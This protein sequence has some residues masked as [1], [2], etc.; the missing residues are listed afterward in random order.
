MI[1]LGCREMCK[2]VLEVPGTALRCSF[3]TASSERRARHSSER[4]PGSV[5]GRPASGMELETRESDFFP[6]PAFQ[7]VPSSTIVQW[8]QKACHR[9]GS[10][11]LF[12]TLLQ[13]RQAGQPTPSA[14]SLVKGRCGDTG[15]G[16]YWSTKFI[17]WFEKQ[18]I[19][20]FHLIG[21]VS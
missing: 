20:C 4:N 1:W 14:Q 10:L 6:Q 15:P 3:A 21:N 11:L 8:S 13:E 19:T 12:P 2:N 7:A 9:Q 18:R 16:S 17:G 5:G